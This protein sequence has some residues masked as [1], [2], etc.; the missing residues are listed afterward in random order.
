MLDQQ[1]S[2]TAGRMLP[3]RSG[4][5]SGRGLS[6]VGLLC[7]VSRIGMPVKL[8]RE[9]DRDRKRA[10]RLLERISCDATVVGKRTYNAGRGDE[11]RRSLD[12]ALPFQ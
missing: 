2:R 10:V 9:I 6:S 8:R 11:S 1:A 5:Q 7:Q 12:V 3:Y 4:G